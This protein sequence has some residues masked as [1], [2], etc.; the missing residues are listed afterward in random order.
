MNLDSTADDRFCDIVQLFHF[1]TVSVPL[2]LCGLSYRG[3]RQMIT[4]VAIWTAA[5]AA[6]R[7]AFFAELSGT[8][9]MSLAC[10]GGS[11]ARPCRTSLRLTGNSCR[12]DPA[13]A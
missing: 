12:A 2:C 1:L 4:P 8:N 9:R 13:E 7:I 3:Q 5:S 11:G 10:I 6:R